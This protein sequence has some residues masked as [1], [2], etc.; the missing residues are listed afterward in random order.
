MMPPCYRKAKKIRQK[1][2]K[3]ITERLLR[4]ELTQPKRRIECVDK[5]ICQTSMR[6]LK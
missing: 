1:A 3:R 6:T 2:T 4:F 5:K